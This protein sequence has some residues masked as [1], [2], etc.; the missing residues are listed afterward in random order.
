[1]PSLRPYFYRAVAGAILLAIAAAARAICR[2][3]E[4]R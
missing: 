2:L 4:I 3:I 1:M